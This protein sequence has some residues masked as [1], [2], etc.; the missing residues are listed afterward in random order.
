VESSGFLSVFQGGHIAFHA[1]ETRGYSEASPQPPPSPGVYQLCLCKTVKSPLTSAARQKERSWAEFLEGH[2]PGTSSC[3]PL[4][5]L[6]RRACTQH[7]CL[8]PVRPEEGDLLTFCSICVQVRRNAL[9][10]SLEHILETSSVTGNCPG[11]T[12]RNTAAGLGTPISQSKTA[13]QNASAF[14]CGQHQPLFSAI[15]RV[16][17]KTRGMRTAQEHP[18]HRIRQ[19]SDSTELSHSQQSIQARR[20]LTLTL[21]EKTSFSRQK[22]LSSIVSWNMVCRV[23]CLSLEVSLSWRP[24]AL[25]TSRQ[26]PDKGCFTL[27]SVSSTVMTLRCKSRRH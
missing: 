27:S 25:A 21:T 19:E 26:M 23:R 7:G 1:L 20:P 9:A 12:E 4:R 13:E 10:R 6:Q 2:D 5:Q 16:L 14:A 17:N 8:P 22:L 11:K 3:H 18:M 24:S 15:S